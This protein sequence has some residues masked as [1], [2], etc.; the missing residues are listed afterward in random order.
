[1]CQ[2]G[3]VT[4]PETPWQNKDPLQFFEN[5]MEI[6]E[7][8]EP[9]EEETELKNLDKIWEKMDTISPVS[10]HRTWE[11]LG[12]F[13]P[14]KE[15][16]FASESIEATLHIVNISQDNIFIDQVCYPINFVL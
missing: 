15:P 11:S 7:I 1:M 5:Y 12:K 3:I 9:T 2:E 13:E 6:S 4:E 8:K 16:P 14:I 10:S